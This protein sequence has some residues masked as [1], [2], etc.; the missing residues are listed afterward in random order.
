MRQDLITILKKLD[1]QVRLQAKIKWIPISYNLNTRLCFLFLF[2]S[3][4]SERF[5][6]FKFMTFL[7]IKQLAELKNVWQNHLVTIKDL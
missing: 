7:N 5:K 1:P 3:F 4:S 6:T 2:Y